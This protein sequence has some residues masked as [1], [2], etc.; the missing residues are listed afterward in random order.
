MIRKIIFFLLL[1]LP[2]PAGICPAAEQTPS[3][4][5]VGDKPIYITSDRLE[6][7]DAVNQ[8]KFE[9]EVVAKQ[10]DV[11]IYADRMTVFYRP[12]DREVERVEALRNVRIVQGTK[13]ATGQKG[14]YFRNEGRIVLTGSPK[15]HQGEDFVEG[16]EITVF[17][18]EERSIVS[19]EGGSRVNAVFHPKEQ[20]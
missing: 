5:A 16:D 19:S 4:P 9:G 14:V 7:D 10:G 3:R 17:L 6:A 15:V 18:G 8:V 11:V 1:L 13:V 12:E 20:K 2:F